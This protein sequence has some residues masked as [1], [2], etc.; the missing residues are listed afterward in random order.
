MKGLDTRETTKNNVYLEK[1]W[2]LMNI[3]GRG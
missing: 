3:V 1:R 2:D